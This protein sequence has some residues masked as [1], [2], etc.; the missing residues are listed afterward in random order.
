MVQTGRVKK[1]TEIKTLIKNCFKNYLIFGLIKMGIDLIFFVLFLLQSTDLSFMGTVFMKIIGFSL[2]KV[3]RLEN[4]ITGTRGA[5]IIYL[6]F[7]LVIIVHY[8]VFS[9][10]VGFL[11]SKMQRNKIVALISIGI[12]YLILS[13]PTVIVGGMNTPNI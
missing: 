11:Y 10:C 12:I 2:S 9:L 4:I 8:I 5:I 6:T 13:L 3:Y 1:M 7:F